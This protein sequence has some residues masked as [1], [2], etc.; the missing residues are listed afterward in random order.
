LE[1]ANPNGVLIRAHLA[2]MIVNYLANALDRQ[3]DLTKDCSAFGVSIQ[4]ETTEMQK[5]MKLACQ[6]GIMGIHTDGT[7]LSDFMPRK[8][9]SRAEF[10]TVL[11]RILWGDTYNDSKPYYVKHLQ[12]L[13]NS[14]IMTQ[15]DNPEKRLELRKWVWVMLMRS[16]EGEKPASQV[17]NPASQVDKASLVP[18]ANEITTL[19]PIE[20]SHS[21]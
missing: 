9:V 7:A 21:T 14:G 20:T 12:A 10:G 16:V 18:T 11:S 4:N 3:P 8:T 13:K 15:I 17:D 19:S 5:Y 1:E 6:Y 2:K